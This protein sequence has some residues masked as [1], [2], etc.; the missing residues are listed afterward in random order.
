MKLTAQLQLKPTKEQTQALRITMERAN[1]ACDYISAQ[2]W[3]HQTFGQF[4]LH[5]L[6]Y[7]Q[8]RAEFG[9]AAQMT[10]RCITKVVDAYKLDKKV[11]RTFKP[12]GAIAYDD[13]IL[14]YKLQSQTVSIWTL[15][16]RMEIPFV[17][18]ERQ[19]ELLQT[20]QGESDLCLVKGKWFLMATCNIEEPELGDIKG[21]IGCD[22]GIVEIVTTS[23]GKGY[24]GAP[25]KAVRRRYKRIR[26][27]LQKRGTKNAKRHLKKLS[28]RQTNFVKNENHCISKQLST[29]PEHPKRHSHLKTS[30]VLENTGTASIR[31]CAGNW[32]FAQLQGFVSYKAQREGVCVVAV[33]ARHTSR[34]CSQCGH[35][36]KENRKNQ[37][38]FC[39]IQCGCELNADFNASLNIAARGAQSLALL[40]SA[41]SV[42]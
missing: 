35:C 9:L 31:R 15:N 34:T 39:C 24:S 30:K 10:V 27:L 1:A 25:T 18:G 38:H 2:A 32:A 13:R 29:M 40:Q 7:R 26:G 6:S 17:C 20:Q 12:T 28:Q 22:M 14:R 37:S 33:D 42:L 41:H 8:V 19:K 23:E 36:A 4:N 5:H 3:Q 21:V 16:G 11:Q